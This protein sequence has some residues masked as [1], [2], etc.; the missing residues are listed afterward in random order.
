VGNCHLEHWW[1]EALDCRLRWDAR[2]VYAVAFSPDGEFLAFADGPTVHL[3]QVSG[4]DTDT[5]TGTGDTGDTR[6]G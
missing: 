2:F 6:D 4:I 3:E 1:Q 5:D